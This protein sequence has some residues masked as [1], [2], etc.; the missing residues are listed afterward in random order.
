MVTSK[1]FVLFDKVTNR[2]VEDTSKIR[3]L[4]PPS[5]FDHENGFVPICILMPR[6][7]ENSEPEAIH[8]E[9]EFTIG[10]AAENKCWNVATTCVC[11]NHPDTEL[12][13]KKRAELAKSI[14]QDD[15]REFALRDFDLLDAQRFF[16]PN[17]FDFKLKTVGV[18]TNEEIVTE[19]CDYMIRRMKEF[20]VFLN[21][22]FSIQALENEDQACL[23]DPNSHFSLFMQ[24]VSS[25]SSE[26]PELFLRIEH[27]DY[28]LGKLIEFFLYHLHQK[29]I[30]FVAFVKKH[31][32]DKH[33]YVK[34]MYN[35]MSIDTID[36]ERINH[37][38]K[39]VADTIIHV[40]EHIAKSFFSA[41]AALEHAE[42][43]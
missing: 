20:I 18:L 34:Y 22:H 4:F 38:L 29:D 19:A 28:T 6:V 41:S 13:A 25:K 16:L 26:E 21:Q 42:D 36:N 23:E 33:A 7:S 39:S 15:A 37:D 40:Y 30:Y 43:E 2:E 11:T 1:D 24:T 32:S 27:D 12:G 31:P 14:E 9:L 3:T 35:K 8:V 10:T 17:H 5:P